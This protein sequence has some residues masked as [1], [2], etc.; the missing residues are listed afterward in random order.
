MMMAQSIEIIEAQDEVIGGFSS[1]LKAGFSIRNRSD[2]TI[3]LKSF[4]QAGNTSFVGGK[5][6]L[7]KQLMNCLILSY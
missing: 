5:I 3:L 6:V 7:V 2:K 4:H 1:S